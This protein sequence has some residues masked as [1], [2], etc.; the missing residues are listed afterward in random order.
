MRCAGDQGRST[1]PC[2]RMVSFEEASGAGRGDWGGS[3]NE[4]CRMQPGALWPW[5]SEAADVSAPAGWKAQ[6]TTTRVNSRTRV[7]ASSGFATT[8][9]PSQGI[10]G[11]APG[12]DSADWRSML[13]RTD[14]GWMVV[15]VSG[16]VNLDPEGNRVRET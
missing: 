4:G 3:A 14:T 12:A 11:L 10:E 8:L 15:G 5:N 13:P 2:G 1:S 7:L 16:K 9:H 6:T